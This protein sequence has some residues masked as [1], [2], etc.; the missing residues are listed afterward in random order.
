MH[1]VRIEPTNLILV[2][3][4]ITYQATGDAVN[5]PKSPNEIPDSSTHSVDQPSSERAHRQQT[6]GTHA[7]TTNKR[8]P[9]TNL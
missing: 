6:N 2:G 9:R 7:Q 8:D 5:H 1:S 3:T 4:N